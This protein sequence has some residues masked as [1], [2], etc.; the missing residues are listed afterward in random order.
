[1]LFHGLLPHSFPNT[2]NGSTLYKGDENE[3]GN[4]YK[5]RNQDDVAQ[6]RALVSEVHKYH[7]DIS[8]FQ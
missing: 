6:I 3:V 5:V 7:H 4:K 8:S 1:M 2:T